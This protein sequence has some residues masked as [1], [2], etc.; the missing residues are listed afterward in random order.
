MN[1]IINGK[2]YDTNTAKQIGSR[3]ANKEGNFFFRETLYR[4]KFGEFFLAVI[5]NGCDIYAGDD[6]ITPISIE[7]AQ[8]WVSKN[9]DGDEYESIF[10]PVQEDKVQV[11][12]WITPSLKLRAGELGCANNVIFAAGVDALEQKAKERD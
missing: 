8:K 9:M 1:K 7:Q 5:Y 11:S 4:K 6:H 10:G 3:D 2:R 12:M